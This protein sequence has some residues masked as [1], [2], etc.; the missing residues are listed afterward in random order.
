MTDV[1][2]RIIY[3][4]R[5]FD[6]K[7]VE[8]KVLE[9]QEYGPHGGFDDKRTIFITTTDTERCDQ[10]DTL[11]HE[12]FH[13]VASTLG[14][15]KEMPHALHQEERIV[16]AFSAATSELIQRNPEVLE[17][18]IDNLRGGHG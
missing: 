10:A 16:H 12:Y 15:F 14:L 1:P 5:V 9:E 4:F 6:V 11:L 2:K 13:G 7:V 8:P 3:S 17:W 18:L